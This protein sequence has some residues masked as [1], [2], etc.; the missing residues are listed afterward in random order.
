LFSFAENARL[1]S[2]I[3]YESWRK[4]EMKKLRGLTAQEVAERKA[5]GQQ[6][7][8]QEDASKINETDIQ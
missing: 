7:D 3:I 6:N 5:A 2:V 4:M 1:N 8:Y